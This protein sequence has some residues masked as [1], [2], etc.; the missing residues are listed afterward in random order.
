MIVIHN[1]IKVIAITYGIITLLFL[2]WFTIELNPNLKHR[3]TA[4]EE[5]YI[6]EH[7]HE[8][9]FIGDE[10]YPPF[11]FTNNGIATGYEAE[12]IRYLESY[13]GVAINYEQRNWTDAIQL[14]DSGQPVVITGMK[15]TEDRQEKYQYT[16]PYLVTTQSLIFSK[17]K[18][19][20]S[21][22]DLQQLEVIA[23]SN[24]ITHEIAKQHNPKNIHLV[25]DPN[26]AIHF[27]INGIGDVWIENQMTALYY[28]RL[29]N[30]EHEFAMKVLEET[31]GYYAMA[32]PK[33]Y[34]T[35]LNI[36]D[37]A[38][39]QLNKNGTIT[40]LD[41]KWFGIVGHRSY[42]ERPL[43]FYLIIL[44]HV[45]L[46]ILFIF[47]L[48]TKTL[49]VQ[50][51]KKTLDLKN[52]NQQLDEERKN[53]QKL[54]EKIARSFST[55]IDYRDDYTGNHSRRVMS[56]SILIANELQLS[57][58]EL[59]E[60]YLGSLLH[61]IGKVGIPDSILKKEGPL[62]EEEY[63]IIKQ[64]PVI[65]AKILGNITSYES[66][67]NAV[68][69]HHERWDGNL[70]PP[71]SAYPGQVQG[72]DIPLVARIISVADAF[73]AMTTDRPYR[74]AISHREAMER[75][76]KESGKQFDPSIVD[77]FSNIVENMDVNQIQK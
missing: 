63:T 17:Q 42:A 75:V 28:L 51:A 1:N 57:K 39:Y 24:S 56:L 12:L 31:S 61:D 36:L 53:I 46:T 55:A 72:E 69:Y 58:Q 6:K 13:L 73:D 64:H 45:L 43:S 11:S 77:C 26:E 59:F 68:L 41:N 37:K 23:Q 50:L 25:K 3:L 15:I 20:V 48:W 54:L 35:L 76:R 33:E 62:T 29:Y 2:L 67:R 70:N 32:L 40:F 74:K 27:L 21:I 30:Q 65:G 19:E 38:M 8:I 4:S 49:H 60:T 14:L 5:Q 34:K 9:K 10:A 18:G 16:A 52:A 44:A 66:I 7:L 47:Y 22:S 71:Y